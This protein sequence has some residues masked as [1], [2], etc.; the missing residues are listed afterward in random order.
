MH[1]IVQTI[2]FQCQFCCLAEGKLLESCS[3]GFEQGAAQADAYGTTIQEDGRPSPHRGKSVQQ[4]LSARFCFNNRRAMAQQTWTQGVVQGHQRV[5]SPL[6]FRVVPG[7]SLGR[8]SSLCV[9]FTVSCYLANAKT[10]YPQTIASATR[11][12]WPATIITAIARH[13]AAKEQ[14]KTHAVRQSVRQTST[15][16]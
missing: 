15:W 2:G 8:T 3:L 14:Q 13:T 1:T 16:R 7:I 5:H 9:I 6:V 10:S 4:Q 11:K 12:E